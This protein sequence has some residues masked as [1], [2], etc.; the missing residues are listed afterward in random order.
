MKNIPLLLGTIIGTVVLIVAVAFMFSKPAA[1]PEARIVDKAV[2][3]ENAT[4]T[5]GNP[6]SSITVVEFS[7]FQCPSCK[8]AEPI[9]QQLKNDYADSVQFV[10]RHFPLD[11]IHPNARLASQ[12]AEAAAMDDKFW[13]YHDLLFVNQEEWSD[14]TDKNKVLEKFSEYATQLEIDKDTFLE[15]IE[16][17][18][19][20]GKVSAEADLAQA[21]GVNSTPTFFVNG[22]QTAAPQLISTVESLK[23][24]SN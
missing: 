7:D 8:V 15:R 6:E 1:T 24:Q 17:E 9:V 21:I 20:I 13:E 19:V 16:S 18:E 14:I 10:Y 3:L 4:N 23:T 22:Q 2:L 5:F 12:A 11:S